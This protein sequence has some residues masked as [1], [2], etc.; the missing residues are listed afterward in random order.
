[1][2]SKGRKS[3][4]LIAL[5][6]VA[7]ALVG[8]VL[9]LNAE[10]DQIPTGN[11]IVPTNPSELFDE[12]L[13]TGQSFI[14]MITPLTNDSDENITLRTAELLQP[15]GVG[16]VIEI[17]SVKAALL[18]EVDD[19]LLAFSLGDYITDPLTQPVGRKD[20]RC[21][22]L[23]LHE[24]EGLTIPPGRSAG[25]AMRVDLIGVGDFATG[26]QRIVY[27][28][29]AGTY[30]QTMRVSRTGHVVAEGGTRVGRKDQRDCLTPQ[31]DLVP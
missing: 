20:P 6:V 10:R 1:M 21:L 7:L 8:V 3:L 30:E 27:R 25:I 23:T 17:S 24:I 14:T 16:E 19:P 13:Q 28:T 2:E 4:V 31:N 9:W 18:P 15:V 29:G 12:R 26:D 5:G 22:S 11:A